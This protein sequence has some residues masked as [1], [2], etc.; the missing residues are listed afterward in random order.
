MRR[1][2]LLLL[3]VLAVVPN[4]AAAGRVA[5]LADCDARVRAAPRALEG[6]RCYWFAARNGAPWSEAAQRLERA[7]AADPANDAAR[8]VLG[9]MA[10]DRGEA[11]ASGLLRTA[12]A[13][14]SARGD[15]EGEVHARVTLAVLLRARGQHAAA[16]VELGRALGRAQTARRADLEA[17]TRV[18]LAWQAYYARDYGTAWARWREAERVVFPGGSIFDRLQTA[19][20]C[21]ATLWSL[22]RHEEALAWY[23]REIGLLAGSDPFR[24]AFVRRNEALLVAELVGAGAREPAELAAAARA[25]LDAARAS[26]NRRAEIG[27]G[28]LLARA[29]SPREAATTARAALLVARASGS[30][31]DRIW[32][33][34]EAGRTLLAADA[35]RAG[36]AFALVDE[37]VALATEYDDSEALADALVARARMCRRARPADEALAAGAAALAAIERIRGLQADGTVRSRVFARFAP[38]WRE[39][40]GT[41]FDAAGPAAGAAAARAFTTAE[42]MRAQSLLETLEAAGVA[43]LS[44]DA[45]PATVEALAGALAPD[46]ALLAFVLPGQA[47]AG[48]WSFTVTAR[49]VT[50]H[51]IARPDRVTREVLVY[52]ALLARRDGSASG[53][54]IRLYE[55]LLSEPLAALPA[56]VTRLVIVPD[57]ALHELP[58]ETLRAAPAAASLA[59]RYELTFAPSAATWLRWRAAPAAAGTIPALSFADP[60]DTALT[61]LPWGLREAQRLAACWGA[62]SVVRSGTGASESALV[63]DDLARYRVLHFAVHAEVDG[64]H[65]ELSALRLAPG[66]DSDGRLSYQE[67]AAL[68]LRGQ[69]VLL[70]ACNGAAGPVLG[71]EGVMGL[72]T[73]FLHAGAR[74]VVAA[75]WPVRDDE[76]ARFMAAFG[77]RLAAGE[78]LGAALAAARGELIR[79]GAPP[80]AW[81]AFAVYGHGDVAPFSGAQRGTVPV[82]WPQRFGVV[83]ALLAVVFA[84]YR[85]VRR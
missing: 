51:R 10:V 85:S 46:Q 61:P 66:G 35:S 14:F 22:G 12:V 50:A 29:L 40:V 33:L 77:E 2:A 15:V 6:W 78:R 5:S 64:A 24:A 20:G 65:P 55:T 60:A 36:E 57:G 44:G 21:A 1:A 45:G 16:G 18:Q 8:L 70:S 68:A 39:A 81:A 30:V 58:L 7:L 26:A 67:I 38:F 3:A 72:S 83:L 34:S 69:T 9:A 59:Q 76:A 52:A 71:G 49:G 80:A 41:E 19:D 63:R 37:A 84:L 4:A 82:S 32:A 53:G 13:G 43:H 62:G 11:R 31:G 48:G 47:D 42:R 27:A 73:A 79:R 75:R 17:E 74:A 56:G 28:L 23:E 54:A 25:A